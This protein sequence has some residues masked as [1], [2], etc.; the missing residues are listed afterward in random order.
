MPASLGH[1]SHSTSAA[2][3]ATFW[4]AALPN[5]ELC[6]IPDSAAFGSVT[7]SDV[8]REIAKSAKEAGFHVSQEKL[9]KPFVIGGV[10]NGTQTC[11][12]RLNADLGVPLTDGTAATMNWKPPI[13]EGSGSGLPGLLGLDSMEENRAILDIGNKKLIYPGP[14]EVQYIL[15]P[16]FA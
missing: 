12:Y 4:K 8:A 10:A 9:D 15:P 5:G 7:G 3:R 16:W 13:V 2:V 14:G 11:N 1:A 6:I